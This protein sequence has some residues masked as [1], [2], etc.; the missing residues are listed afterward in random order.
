VYE[1]LAVPRSPMTWQTSIIRA[2]MAGNS[3][4]RR[5]WLPSLL[6]ALD[7]PERPRFEQRYAELARERIRDAP[8]AARSFRFAGC[9]SSPGLARI[10]LPIHNF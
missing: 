8:T 5:S 1:S 9:S 2:L 4:V 10:P 6:D 7:E 3:I